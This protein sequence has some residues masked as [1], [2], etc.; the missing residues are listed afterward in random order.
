MLTDTGIFLFSYGFVK[1]LYVMPFSVTST[2][3]MVMRSSSSVL[4]MFC[5]IFVL[6]YGILDLYV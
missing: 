3:N 4:F 6:C 2:L 5:L 1:A